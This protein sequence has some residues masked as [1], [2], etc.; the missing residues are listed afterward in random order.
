[1]PFVHGQILDLQQ[2]SLT[3]ICPYLVQFIPCYPEVGGQDLAVLGVK[4]HL[5]P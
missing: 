3:A 4:D 2:T 5:Q 1:M